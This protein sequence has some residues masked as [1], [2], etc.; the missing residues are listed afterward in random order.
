[1]AHLLEIA[2]PMESYF[3]IMQGPITS[4][5]KHDVPLHNRHSA[6]P[7]SIDMAI[8]SRYN[9]RVEASRLYCLAASSRACQST[10]FIR[11]DDVVIAGARQAVPMDEGSVNSSGIL[12][13]RDPGHLRPRAATA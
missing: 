6:H 9:F 8:L 2:C 11:R 10:R 13:C 4:A 5:L 1:M 12:P 7:S 3:P